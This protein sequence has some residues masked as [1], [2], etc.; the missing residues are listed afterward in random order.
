MR[1]PLPD[2]PLHSHVNKTAQFRFG[3]ADLRFQLSHALFS[4]F[5]IDDG[6]RLLLKSIAERVDLP[7]LRSVLD[8]G[9]GVGV[10]GISIGARASRAVVDM[11]DRDA[12]A[13][14]FARD[15][16]AINGVANVSVSASLAFESLADRRYDLIVSNLPA[17]AGEPVIV[18]LFQQS[19]ARL[20]EAGRACF[21]IVEPLDGLAR[22][23]AAEAGLVVVAEEKSPR[24]TVLHLHRGTAGPGERLMTF[25]LE[26]YVRRHG[27]FGFAGV[28]WEADTAWSL[29]EFDTLGHTVENALALL[30]SLD[31]P[32]TGRTMVLN[33]GQGHLPLFLLQRAGPA[34][35]G[36]RLAGR[37]TLALAISARNLRAAGHTPAKVLPLPW[38]EALPDHCAP[39]SLDMLTAIP[40]PVPRVPWQPGL[41]SAARQLLTPGGRLLVSSSSTE[42]QRLLASHPGFR[43]GNS[44]RHAG[45]RAVWLERI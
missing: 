21:V 9:C 25:G 17:K 13:A 20:A 42:I 33:P 32:L 29:P 41:L 22:S 3:G 27:T 7:S 35:P 19:G 6:S 26:P 45:W 1:P 30:E 5:A 16:A 37:D 36:L 39:G 8:V 11:E 44:R 18:E 40:V 31:S 23:A 15:N 2:I 10:L 14:A 43:A 38:Y 28:S 24:Y 12:L 34:L 4:S